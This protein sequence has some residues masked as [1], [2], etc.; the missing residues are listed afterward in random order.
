MHALALSFQ[1][2]YNNWDCLEIERTWLL[3]LKIIIK[4]NKKALSFVDLC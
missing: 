4:N 3:Y 2:L 1:R